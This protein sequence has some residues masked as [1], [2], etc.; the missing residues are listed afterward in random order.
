MPVRRVAC[1]PGKERERERHS[2]REKKERRE[3][4]ELDIHHHLYS[5]CYGTHSPAPFILARVDR[6]MDRKISFCAPL[7]LLESGKGKAMMK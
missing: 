2:P 7:G 3:K 6:R 5:L 1:V 4:G